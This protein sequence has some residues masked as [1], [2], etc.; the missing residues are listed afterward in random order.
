ML[1]SGGVVKA[2]SGKGKKFDA[3][4]KAAWLAAKA[5][6]VDDAKAM[7]EAGLGALQTSAE[8]KSRQGPIPPVLGRPAAS[9]VRQPVRRLLRRAERRQPCS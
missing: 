2:K 9:Q 3:A 1:E 6:K 7:L 4:A 8:W 5:A